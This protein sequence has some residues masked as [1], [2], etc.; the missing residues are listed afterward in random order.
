[1][2]NEFRIKN[3]F[4]SQGNSNITGS[5]TVSAGITGSLFGTASFATTAS[6]LNSTT[7][8]FIQGGNSFGSTALL[9][10]NDTRDLN[11]ET[12]GTGRIFISGSDGAVGIG[13]AARIDSRLGILETAKSYTVYA[14]NGTANGTAVFGFA[15]AGS[16]TMVGVLGQSSATGATNNIG[17]DGS[18]GSGTNNYAI[19]LQDGTEGIGKVLVSQTADGKAN[20]STRLTGNYEITGSL[21]VSAGITGSLL[22]TASFATSASRAVS[23]SRSDS[24]LSASFATTSATASY[25]LNSVSASFSNTASYINPLNQN[26][27]ITGSLTLS[28]SA[29]TSLTVQKTAT[30]NGT[31]SFTSDVQLQGTQYYDAILV[32]T[33]DA[34]QTDVWSYAMPTGTADT[35]EVT[36]LGVSS[37]LSSPDAVGGNLVG[38]ARCQGG[39]ASIVGQSTSS[40]DSFSSPPAFGLRRQTATNNIHFWVRGLA[41]T[42]IDWSVAVRKL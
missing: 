3:G 26:V 32:T 12:N 28:G 24:A 37:S 34:T 16:G 5:L 1:M 6:F 29:A 11:F 22:G 17:L 8:A 42:E 9:G 15:Q 40:F 30:F 31:A 35:I 38:V 7:N 21:I 19:R 39:L 18:A 41:S 33:T 10:T 2:A 13:T 27:T 25:V 36:V 4:E 23:A 14:N 20:W